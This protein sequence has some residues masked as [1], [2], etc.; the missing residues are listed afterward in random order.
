[1]KSNQ[2]IYLIAALT[3]LI[4]GAIAA[5]PVYKHSVAPVR[6]DRD[7]D[8]EAPTPAVAIITCTSVNSGGVLG[9][10]IVNNV[11]FSLG[12][13]IPPANFAKYATGSNCAEA[14][15][16]LNELGFERQDADASAVPQGTYYSEG[17]L[18]Y[19]WTYKLPNEKPL[20]PPV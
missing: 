5:G 19:T 14:L 9:Q 20:L 15:Q 4:L 1:M 8:R 7:G 10:P 6:A 12:L 11:D 13:V 16:A 2:R 3:V 17:A 18:F